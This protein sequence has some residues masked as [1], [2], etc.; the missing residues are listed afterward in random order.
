MGNYYS[1]SL[2]T[3][4]ALSTSNS[5]GG[6]LAKREPEAVACISAKRNLYTRRYQ[7]LKSWASTFDTAPLC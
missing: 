5:D 6:M 3:L 1:N 4:S 2:F 7:T